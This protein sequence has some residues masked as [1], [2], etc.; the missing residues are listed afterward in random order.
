MLEKRVLW[1]YR[2]TWDDVHRGV[3]QLST[4]LFAHHIFG[5]FSSMIIHSTSFDRIEDCRLHTASMSTCLALSF[6]G[7]LLLLL[8]TFL[9]EN[10]S[11]ISGW[12]S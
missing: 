2:C 12:S 3:Y 5:V 11:K 10:Q 8:L 7:L 4:L 6:L 1:I 9:S